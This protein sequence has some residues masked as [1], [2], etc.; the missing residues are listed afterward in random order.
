MTFTFLLFDSGFSLPVYNGI[1]LNLRNH[2]VKVTKFNFP[3]K[4]QQLTEQVNA[5]QQLPALQQL[6]ATLINC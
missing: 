6:H 3:Q 5:L 2:T 1:A 4:S